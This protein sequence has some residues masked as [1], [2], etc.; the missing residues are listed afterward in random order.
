MT[1]LRTPLCDLLDIDVPIMQAGRG[2]IA[3][4]DLAAAATAGGRRC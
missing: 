2:L 3:Y 1:T 4:A